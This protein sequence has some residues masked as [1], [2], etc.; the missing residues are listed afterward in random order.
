MDCVI[1]FSTDFSDIL[2]FDITKMAPGHHHISKGID[3]MHLQDLTKY[4]NIVIQCH[5]NPDPDAIASGFALFRFFSSDPSRSVRLVYAGKYL[6]Q[7]PNIIMMTERLSIPIHHVD[8]LAE[9]PELLV[10]VDG[11]YGQGNVTM[12]PG[13]HIAVIDHHPDS[14]RKFEYSDIRSAYGSCSTVVYQLLTDSGFDV[15]D[16]IDLATAL[17]YGLYTDTNSFSEISHPADKDLRDDLVFNKSLMNALRNANLSSEDILLAGDALNSAFFDDDERFAV[18]EAGPCD[19]NI[20]GFISDMLIQVYECDSCVVFCRLPFGIKYSVRSCTPE[21]HAGEMARALSANIGSGGGHAEKAGGFLREDSLSVL[22][23][24]KE[25]TDI[26]FFASSI[27]DYKSS[28]DIIYAS[29]FEPDLSVMSVYIKNRIPLGFVRSLDVL[30]DGDCATVRTLEGD[31]N[32]RASEDIYIMIGVSGEVYPIQRETFDKRYVPS[33]ETYSGVFEYAPTIKQTHTQQ[34]V[35]LTDHALVCI[36][37]E[38]THIYARP[39]DRT[40]K[41]FTSWDPEHY[42]L[43]TPGDMLAAHYLNPKDVYVIAQE[44]FPLTYRPVEE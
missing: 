28:Y 6:I 25:C 13:E 3:F 27:C 42:M 44:I 34:S 37:T 12:L 15:N 4:K 33:D 20:L 36:P 40:V 38:D 18:A 19:P 21:L 5:D 22:L 39:I 10:I 9:V 17:Y 41:V 23:E 8:G 11:Q 7:K 1:C 32:I 30:N 14:E 24:Q 35:A 43:G 2:L 26:E 16:D 29:Q 31:I